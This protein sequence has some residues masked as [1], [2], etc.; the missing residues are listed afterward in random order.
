MVTRAR[1]KCEE[2]KLQYEVRFGSSAEV[3]SLHAVV[4]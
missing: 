2:M 4:R 3:D 1:A